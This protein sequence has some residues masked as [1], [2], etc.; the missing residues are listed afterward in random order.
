MRIVESVSNKNGKLPSLREAF[1][2]F[3]KIYKESNQIFKI[4]GT[5]PES[6]I[7]TIANPWGETL[8][9]S[10]AN[11]GLHCSGV[12]LVALAISSLLRQKEVIS[13]NEQR[14]IVGQAFLHDVL[15]PFDV[16]LAI[17][18]KSGQISLAEYYSQEIF[19]PVKDVL[20]SAGIATTTAT[21]LVDNIGREVNVRQC[22][23]FYL[24]KDSAGNIK[25]LPGNIK[26]KVILVSDNSCQTSFSSKEENW[27]IM[28]ARKRLISSDSDQR[29]P[30]ASK[31]GIGFNSDGYPITILDPTTASPESKPFLPFHDMLV[32]LSEHISSEFSQRLGG[33]GE[34][35]ESWIVNQAT[36]WLLDKAATIGSTINELD[37]G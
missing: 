19:E 7:C 13:K 29:Y 32:W 21:S 16:Y 25:L 34:N 4:L 10:F 24:K 22:P 1:Y 36:N 18:L 9:E 33:P 8:N 30:W 26:E 6:K 12:A 17:A 20:I 11:V 28:S 37:R 15:K 23:E 27:N 31:A 35:C 14:E 3:E 2:C 5:H